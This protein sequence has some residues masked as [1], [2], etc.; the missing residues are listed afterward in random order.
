MKSK[1]KSSDLRK[2]SRMQLAI[3][4]AEALEENEKLKAQIAE[5]QTQLDAKE[6]VCTNSQSLA[7]AAL[8]LSGI[9]EA[10]DRAVE[11][12]TKSIEANAGNGSS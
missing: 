2:L 11:I 12:Y 9:F 3:K 1:E 4:L 10:A 8:Q 6:L 5:L 7:Q